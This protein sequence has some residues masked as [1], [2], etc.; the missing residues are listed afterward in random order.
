MRGCVRVDAGREGIQHRR[1]R[2]PDGERVHRRG[3]PQPLERVAIGEGLS[4]ETSGVGRFDRGAD[5][6]G[7]MLAKCGRVRG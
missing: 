5:D 3:A 2:L 7:Q 6:G 4:N 1:G